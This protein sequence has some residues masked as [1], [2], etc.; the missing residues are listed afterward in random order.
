MESGGSGGLNK[1]GGDTGVGQEGVTLNAKVR[2]K[3]RVRT[4][5]SADR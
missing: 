2:A 1:R 5:M 3:M 4:K